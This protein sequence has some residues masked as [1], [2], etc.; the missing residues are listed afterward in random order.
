MNVRI[1]LP[2]ISGVSACVPSVTHVHNTY[3]MGEEDSDVE[4]ADTADSDSAGAGS[5]PVMSLPPCDTVV[6]L[7]DV[8][9]DL[10]GQD[11]HTFY[12]EV[13]PEQRVSMDEFEC[14]GGA[15]DDYVIVYDWVNEETCPNF[16][17][18][19][20]VVPG[21]QA[22]GAVQCADT[23]KV[24]LATVGQSSFRYW[25]DVPNFKLDVGE[26]QD[27]RFPSGDKTVRLNNG[28]ADANIVREAIGLGV[29]N[30]M[31]YP[32]PPSRFVRTQSN[33]WDNEVYPGAWAAHVMVQPYKKAFFNAELPSAVHVWEGE[34]DAFSPWDDFSFVECEWTD[35]DECDFDA[36]MQIREFI[37]G[38]PEGEGFMA[39]TESVIDWPAFHQNQCLSALTGTGDDF[40]HNSNN[41]VFVLRE[42]GKIQFLPYSI[43]INA[44]HPW[45]PGTP[46]DGWGYLPQ[47]CAADPECRA[48]ALD[49]CDGMIDTFE[50][51][52]VP[53]TVV[54][55]RCDALVSAGLS[56]A[57]DEEVCEQI[58]EY[59]TSRPE[60]LRAEIE[61]LRF[62]LMQG[63]TEESD[64]DE[65]I[66]D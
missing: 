28:Q 56:R 42:D 53:T 66:N 46:Y 12:L 8:E 38:A 37:N 51:L 63:D 47:Q 17:L 4:A 21:G 55:E 30:A 41:T 62:E 23:G 39:A 7:N 50:A 49:T 18:N 31:G 27:I 3:T 59:Y 36:L 33:V 15:S 65:V 22:E 44:D 52:D 48:A 57:N 60:S 24:E 14:R 2:L 13:T 6:A 16:A 19:V 1:L 11:G 5:Y 61:A 58:R 32:A 10:W 25:Y 43:D 34:A 26:F 20:R 64:T 29:W 40:I 9:I 54:D 45:Y 35:A